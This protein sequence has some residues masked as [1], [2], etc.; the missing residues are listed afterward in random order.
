MG[1]H[2]LTLAGRSIAPK[3]KFLALPHPHTGGYKRTQG[4]GPEA[5]S[6]LERMGRVALCE[7][8]TGGRMVGHSPGLRRAVNT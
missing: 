3:V 4:R 5:V 8:N 6:Q 2:K 7:V 1:R